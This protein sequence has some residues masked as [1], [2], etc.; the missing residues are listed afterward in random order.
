MPEIVTVAEL[1]RRMG[2]A[3]SATLYRAAQ[4]GRLVPA[5]DG[6]GYLADE[7]MVRYRDTQ[8]SGP[9]GQ[10]QRERHAA[11]RAAQAGA[12]RGKAVT[13]AENAPEGAQAGQRADLEARRE[14]Q[15]RAGAAGDGWMSANQAA[16]ALRAARAK[17]AGHEAEISRLTLER[18][19]GK[20][21]ETASI[22]D[23]GERLGIAL[24]TRLEN[25]PDQLAPQLAAQTDTERVHALLVEAVEQVLQDTAR[26][27]RHW[28]QQLQ[29]GA[30]AL[31][32]EAH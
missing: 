26:D 16:D 8:D 17:R 5:P 18:M 15:E 27:L 4:A 1:A 30:V 7:S 24:R 14:E 10:G 32:R 23:A 6:R 19:Q 3:S 11:H 21:A 31:E 2:F 9:I 12:V 29:A 13:E 20:L 22:R 28:L 25:L